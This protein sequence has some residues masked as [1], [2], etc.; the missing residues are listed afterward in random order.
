MTAKKAAPRLLVRVMGDISVERDGEPVPLPQS[1]KTKALLAYLALAPGPHRRSTLCSLLGEMPDDPRAA[2]RWSLTKLRAALDDEGHRRIVAGKE[3]VALDLDGARVDLVDAR[4]RLDEGDGLSVEV[5]E[6]IAA[7]LRSDFAESVELGDSPEFE[8]WCA[9]VREDARNLR[10]RALAH[11]SDR[12]TAEPDRAL[13]YARALVELAPMVEDARAKLV[14]LLRAAGRQNEAERHYS[15]GLRVAKELGIAPPDTLT[16]AWR[17]DTAAAPDR[18]GREDPAANSGLDQEIRF[19]TASDGA[20]LAFATVGEGPPL[21]K[22][23]NWLNHLEYDWESPI[24]RPLFQEL[25]AG[26]TLVRYDERGNGL[27]DWDV[28]DLSFDAFERDLET[29]VDAAG[30]DRFA[31]FGVSQGASVSIAYAAAHP[32]RVSH[33]ILLGGYARGRRMRGSAESED[34]A[35]AFITLMRQ[36]W[37]QD[38]P[39]FRQIFSSIY[40]PDAS[41]EQVQWFNDLQRITTSPENAVRLRQTLDMIDVTGLVPKVTAPTL[42]IHAREDVVAPFEEGRML[43]STIPGARFVPIESRNH[44]LL[45]Q[46]PAWARAVAAI[47]DFLA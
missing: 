36:G 21:V 9:G 35:Q 47:K 18:P 32:D 16:A 38:N 30:L 24:W 3:T 43:A 29:V 45:P 10:T 37:G 19:C 23:A 39:A 44:V 14:R 6:R 25:A 1:Q 7:D 8:T 34:E 4:E 33:L 2:L 41:P 15:E 46:E 27:S 26:N 11:L 17:E 12:L 13:P 42:V 40:V 28:D 31:L 22:A 5:L 20:S